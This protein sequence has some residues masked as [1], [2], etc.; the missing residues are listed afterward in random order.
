MRRMPPGS[1]T[2]SAAA[3]LLDDG[4]AG[5]VCELA[6]EGCEL[7]PVPGL[8]EAQ[9]GDGSLENVEAA[10][11]ERER[12]IEHRSSGSDLFEVPESWPRTSTSST[13]AKRASRRASLSIRASSPC[14]SGS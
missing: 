2:A 12:A 10:A 6:V 9:G 7:R 5:A 1:S 14:T 11:A 13:S 8:V 3:W 4:G